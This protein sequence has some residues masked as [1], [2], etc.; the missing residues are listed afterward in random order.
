MD[1]SLDTDITIHLY[2][3]GKEDL[4]FK[5]FDKLYMHEFI[6]EHEIRNKS[7]EVYK[8]VKKAQ[9]E[10]QII[11][12]NARYLISIGMKKAFEDQLYD[13]KELFDFGEANAVALASTLGIVA[14]ITDDTKEFGP[15]ETLVKEC[16]EDVIPF[17]FYELLYF[18]YLQS[19]DAFDDFFK[20]YNHINKIAYPNR[21]MGFVSRIK[22]V[23]RRFSRRGTKRDMKWMDN[24]CKDKG[25]NYK[26]KMRTLLLHLEEQE[27]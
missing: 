21:P 4:I 6:L 24:F 20:E 27:Q 26:E 13:I 7:V 5:Y 15:H 1:V 19:D 3:A 8:K 16:V 17:A 25:I 14:L 18:E 23:V 11:V 22:R 12:V 9:E 2:H 10:G